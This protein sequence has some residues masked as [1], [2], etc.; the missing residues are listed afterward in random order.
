V[1]SKRI[2]RPKGDFF[3]VIFGSL[4][5][6]WERSK[7]A[8]Q[9]QCQLSIRFACRE[10]HPSHL[11]R[12]KSVRKQNTKN[13]RIVVRT[14]RS[15]H[16]IVNVFSCASLKSFFKSH[17]DESSYNTY[18]LDLRRCSDTR[19]VVFRVLKD[20]ALYRH[21]YSVVQLGTLRYDVWSSCKSFYHVRRSNRNKQ[22][23]RFFFL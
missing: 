23:Y 12:E 11:L 6:R 15:Q 3:L 10:I 16:K 2:R 22:V 14:I 13:K 5:N 4:G 9:T 8:C 7:N 21:L 20:R 17:T 19:A 1:S 18:Y